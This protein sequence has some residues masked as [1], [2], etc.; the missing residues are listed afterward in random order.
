M[1]AIIVGPNLPIVKV[2]RRGILTVP[3]EDASVRCSCPS[4]TCQGLDVN[5]LPL[6]SRAL[7]KYVFTMGDRFIERSR[8]RGYEAVGTLRLHGPWVSYDFN[9]TLADIES[10]ALSS[11]DPADALGFVHNR[12]TFSPYSDYVLVGEFL[13]QVVVLDIPVE[14]N[15]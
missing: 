12:E 7:Q 13:K 2:V 11:E 14:V 3:V 4:P 9:N 5:A 10:A 15:V 6:T 1:P 8:I